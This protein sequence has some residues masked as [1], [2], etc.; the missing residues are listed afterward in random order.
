MRAARPNSAQ[1]IF[2]PNAKIE[3]QRM[4]SGHALLILDDALIEPEQLFSYSVREH[5]AFRN[6]DFN[7]YPGLYLAAP[8]AV[9]NE[10]QEL[11]NLRVRRHFSARRCL[12]LHCRLSLTTLSPT[13]L[14][15]YQWLPHRDSHLLA[16]GQC[17]QASVLYLFRDERLGG[18]SFYEPR[19]PAT[20]TATLF[21]DAT[22]LSAAEFT[23]R[24]GLARGYL[25]GSNDYFECVATI[26]PR[27][28]RMIFYDGSVLHSGDITAPELL[29]TLPSTGR[30]TLNGFFTSTCALS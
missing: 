13:A 15:P 29:S 8:A 7:A 26:A 1:V 18:T 25:H 10:L 11:F 9:V 16:R 2:N 20:E 3:L 5:Q 14:A 4:R 17:I 21:N 27:W 23:Q 19:R 24:H 30:L 28:N 6:V 12:R 22:Q